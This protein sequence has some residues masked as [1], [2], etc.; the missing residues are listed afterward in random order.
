MFDIV[1]SSPPF[2][3]LEKYSSYE[4]NSITHYKDEETWCDQFFV[5]SLIKCYNHLEKDGHM[6]LYMG[7]SKYVF[8]RMFKLN[9]VMAYKGVMYF[10]DNKPRAMYVWK[11]LKDGKIDKL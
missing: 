2:F 10:Y 7:G 6:I 5:K 8:D 3:T 11:K 1:F 9:N 4:D